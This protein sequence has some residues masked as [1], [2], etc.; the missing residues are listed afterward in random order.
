MN[1]RDQ[2]AA[3]ALTGLLAGPAAEP[4]QT[5]REFASE[6]Y[7]MADAMLAERAN[8]QANPDSCD[9]SEERVAT[10]AE[11][12][13]DDA[14]ADAVMNWVSEATT[15][16]MDVLPPGGKS[17]IASACSQCWDAYG[18]DNTTDHDAVPA[19]RATL[20]PADHAAGLNRE[21]DGTDKA[22]PLTRDS[23]T[24]NT[25]DRSQPIKEGVF[26]RSK[27]VGDWRMLAKGEAIL[28]GDEY[29]CGGH[30]HRVINARYV[31]CDA[32]VNQYRRRVTK[33]EVACE[34]R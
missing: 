1:D 20:Q 11:S 7:K 16:L 19:A 29:L 24:G 23:G 9:T 18:K 21:S 22:D 25:P 33:E 3:A 15:M 13:H 8:R 5:F 28:E 27:P 14:F 34:W 17:I 2:F 26:D 6:A 4:T 31:V 10:Q 32:V 30:W 12:Q